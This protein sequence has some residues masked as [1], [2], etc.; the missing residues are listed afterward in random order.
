MAKKKYFGKCGVCKKTLWKDTKFCTACGIVFRRIVRANPDMSLQE[1]IEL[2]IQTKRQLT[3]QIK[4]DVGSK[5]KHLIPTLNA[6]TTE[7]KW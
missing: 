6:Q 7:K 2:T 4:T 3:I 1:H 5:A